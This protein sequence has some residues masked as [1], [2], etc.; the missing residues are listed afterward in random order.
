LALARAF[1]CTV[2]DLFR[3]PRVES[4]TGGDEPAWTWPARQADWDEGIAL[5]PRL[6]LRTIEAVLDALL[7]WV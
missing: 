7:R 5:A 4:A 3:L 1:G 6:D 2:E